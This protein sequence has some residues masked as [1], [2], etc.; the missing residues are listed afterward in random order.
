MRDSATSSTNSSPL[1]WAIS[2]TSECSAGALTTVSLFTGVISRIGLR[3]TRRRHRLVLLAARRERQGEQHGRKHQR[4]E[5]PHCFFSF[6]SPGNR[7]RAA[8]AAAAT[9]VGAVP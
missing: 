6:F 7:V 5:T 4:A 1:R 3:L 9:S 8:L 2:G